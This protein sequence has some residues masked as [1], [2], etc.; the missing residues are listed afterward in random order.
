[1]GSH[2]PPEVRAAAMAALL[3]GQGVG[4]VAAEYRL[5]T[6]TV[7]RWKAEA[8]REA[9]RSDDVGELLLD[10]LRE[11]LSTLT[12]QAVVFRDPVWLKGQAAGEL[13]VLHGVMTDKAVRLL[14]ALEGGPNV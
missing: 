11:N 6:S 9:G 13:A 1:M 8:R 7:S 5:P 10:Y 2:H 14:E 3:A 12:A 4:D